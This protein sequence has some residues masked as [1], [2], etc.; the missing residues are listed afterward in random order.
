MNTDTY[1]WLFGRMQQGA[2]PPGPDC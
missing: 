2:P 1:C